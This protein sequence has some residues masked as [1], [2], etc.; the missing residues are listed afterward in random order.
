MK[1][2][3]LSKNEHANQLDYDDLIQR[4]PA[5]P[6]ANFLWSVYRLSI[7]F[8]NATAR[9]YLRLSIGPGILT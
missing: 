3:F 5:L 8:S 6:P 4:P 7:T 9:P 1:N 2:G